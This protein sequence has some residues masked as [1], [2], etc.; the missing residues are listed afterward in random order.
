MK[1]I[2]YYLILLVFLTN[3]SACAGYKPIFGSTNLEFKIADYEITGNKKI[4]NQIYSRLYNL[5]QSTKGSSNVKNIYILIN[6][7]KNK[8]A[9]SKNSAG[10]ILAYKINLSTTVTVKDFMTDNQ[11]FSERFD[12]GSSYNVQVRHSETIKLEN[13]TLENL[14]NKT[15]QDLLLKLSES[16][17]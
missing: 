11:I 1:K 14:I 4:G 15:Y 6:T 7:S 10:K 5:S 8:S 9:T 12:F 2:Y 16:I 17:L 13:R 3:I